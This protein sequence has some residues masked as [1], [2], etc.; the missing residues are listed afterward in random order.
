MAPILIVHPSPGNEERKR[1]YQ[2]W[3]E[4]AGFSLYWGIPDERFY[5]GDFACL[6]LTGGKDVNPARYGEDAKPYTEID[7]RDG[8]EFDVL[9]KFLMAEKPVLG[10]CRGIQVLNVAF[11]GSLFQDIALERR[12][13]IAHRDATDTARDVFHFIRTSDEGNL[14]KWLGPRAEV[15]S[16]HHQAIKF[17]APGLI[18]TAFA[19]DGIVEGVE[20]RSGRIMGVQWHPERLPEGHPCR[21]APLL[22][23]KQICGIGVPLF[24]EE[25]K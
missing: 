10:I 24:P 1:S 25:Q 16:H 21:L 18:A 14:R 2:V 13:S 3:L 6:I 4:S 22:W 5:P 12:L 23:L 19:E 7:P 9:E 17:L 15:N 8:W 11:G 20:D